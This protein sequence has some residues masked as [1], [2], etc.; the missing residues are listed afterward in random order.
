[1]RPRLVRNGTIEL[2]KFRADLAG[3]LHITLDY[4]PKR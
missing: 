2:W 4:A 3:A 1:L